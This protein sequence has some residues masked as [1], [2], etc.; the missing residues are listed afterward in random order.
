MTKTKLIKQLLALKTLRNLPSRSGRIWGRA[1]RETSP[2][3]DMLNQ[4]RDGAA[5]ARQN[6]IER[7]FA[8]LGGGKFHSWSKG[9]PS[10][11]VSVPAGMRLPAGIPYYAGRRLDSVSTYSLPTSHLR[12]WRKAI[13][14]RVEEIRQRRQNAASVLGSRA[15]AELGI[16][17]GYVGAAG[18][19]GYGV[20]NLIK[21]LVESRKV[22]QGTTAQQSGATSK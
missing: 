6:G 7:G 8:D 3:Y 22:Q 21:K 2:L 19:S 13:L 14:D 12:P 5:K 15:R 11:S 17:G 1:E 20:Y 9:Y 16:A 18:A 4:L 10:V